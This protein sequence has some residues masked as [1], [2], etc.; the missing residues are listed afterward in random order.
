M[1]VSAQ[2]EAPA[3]RGPAAPWWRRLL[4]SPLAG[5]VVC[6]AI[7]AP[8]YVTGH[9]MDLPGYLLALATGWLVAVSFVGATARLPAPWGVWVHVAGA[10]GAV[11]ILMLL[12]S[13]APMPEGI[14]DAL[15]Q[16]ALLPR[17]AAAPAAGW[18]WLTLLARISGRV[19][20]R[21]AARAAALTVP[22]WQHVGN[23]W[24]LEFPAVPIR[25]RSL[26]WMLIGAGAVVAVAAI[27]VLILLYDTVTRFGP[28]LLILAFGVLLAL[29]AHAV[30][31]AIL[32]RRTVRARIEVTV[33]AVR[34]F[35]GTAAEARDT[36]PAFVAPF[37]RTTRV[38]WEESGDGARL[39][40]RRSDGKDLVLLA[41][42]ARTPRGAA[43]RLPPLPRKVMDLFA[44]SGLEPRPSRSDTRR[45]LAKQPA[46][47]QRKPPP[48]RGF[49]KAGVPGLEPRTKVPETS[50]LPITPYPT[51]SDRSRTEDRV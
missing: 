7:A 47:G 51:G 32:R 8:L 50:V 49:F 9:G 37:R 46:P 38:V 19:N 17:L 29:P 4:R 16:L 41:G 48:E 12:A 20:A 24:I 6:V 10:A 21:S 31:T 39:E 18:V 5:A 33:D 26:R 15:R 45:T 3:D 25:P 34:V 23:R 22:A 30:V 27:A 11:P 13:S 42:V 14:P 28:Y 40:A 35:L 36:S 2:P 1:T 43:S 44:R